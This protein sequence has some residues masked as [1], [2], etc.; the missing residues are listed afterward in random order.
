MPYDPLTVEWD[1]DGWVTFRRAD[2]GPG[3]E[4]GPA[5]QAPRGF[6]LSEIV[7][8]A[9]ATG[10]VVDRPGGF[11]ID[12]QADCRTLGGFVREMLDYFDAP[13]RPSKRLMEIKQAVDAW[14]ADQRV[15]ARLS[16]WVYAWLDLVVREDAKEDVLAADD[17]WRDDTLAVDLARHRQRRLRQLVARI[18][19]HAGPISEA[20]RPQTGRMSPSQRQRQGTERKDVG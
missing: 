6:T 1:E 3:H 15:E 8:A 12:R 20:Q 19:A 11:G 16:A 17:L 7:E 4:A 10:W 5:F 9:C 14:L 18:E 13:R 2:E